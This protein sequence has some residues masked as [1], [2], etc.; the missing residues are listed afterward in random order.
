MGSKAIAVRVNE[1]KFLLGE[2][3]TPES[4]SEKLTKK[5]GL[6]KEDILEYT[7]VRESIDARKEIVFSYSLD[8]KVKRP[9]KKQVALSPDPFQWLDETLSNEALQTIRE[10]TSQ[11]EGGRPVV[12]GFGP[13]G[14]FAALQL[15]RAGAAPIILE[16][17]AAIDQRAQAVEQFW[18]TGKL[19]P[20][21][22]V[23]FGEGGAGAFSDGKLTTR[24]KDRR[25][26]LILE[27]FIQ[28]GAPE[29]I[30]YRNKPHI[31]T[32][33]LRHVVKK[34]RQEIEQLGG[35]IYF[36]SEVV[37]F[38]RDAEGH[39]CSLRTKSGQEFKTAY[40]IAA[41]G[42]SAREFYRLMKKEAVALEAKP[43][44]VGVRIEHP[45]VLINA[46]QYGVQHMNSE[47][48]SAEYKLTY[49]SHS[50]RGVYSFCMCPGGL[51]V[52]SASESG[53]LV[54][55][56]MSYHARD[57]YNA[58]SAL[59]VTVEPDDFESDDVLAGVAFQEKLERK[60]FEVGGRNYSAPSERVGTFCGNAMTS[61][62][63]QENR[64]YY[65]ALGVD[66]E[67][68]FSEM[69]A[70]YRPNVAETAL[71]EVLPL[72][73]SEALKEAI[74][75]F[76]NQIPGFDDP[77]AILTAV[78]SRSSAPIRMVRRLDSGESVS[79]PGFFPCGEGAGYAG[80]I[81][82]SAVDGIKAAEHVIKKILG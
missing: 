55:N 20:D 35:K 63:V 73:I 42:H 78:E 38:Q 48:G 36:E 14:I 31:G 15:A 71:T 39:I 7:I 66:Y 37:D 22:N 1:V 30:R 79:L 9:P 81:T 13:A 70:S 75:H 62:K 82:S 60:S 43:F 52:A 12:I 19:N 76:G 49:K 11:K 29:D 72:F 57:L 2:N 56:G 40:V 27:A 80:G 24:I 32:D 4:I 41:V 59:L 34:L 46:A 67:T 18:E 26:E 10:K 5:L 23:Q 33:V 44:A 54:V 77:R 47:L 6:K 45:Q 69:L 21:T 65:K 53:G 3:K 28:A 68:A 16:K 8:V 61:E 64:A 51:V 58:N 17:G 25:I 50:G 74:V